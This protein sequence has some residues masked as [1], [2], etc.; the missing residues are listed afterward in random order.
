MTAVEHA[1]AVKIKLLETIEAMNDAGRAGCK[2][3]FQVDTNPATLQSKLTR[4]AVFQSIA[5]DH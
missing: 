3:E 5:V 1:N 2:F 4:F